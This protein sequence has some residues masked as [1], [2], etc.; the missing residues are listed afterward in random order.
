[1]KKIAILAALVLVGLC[2]LFFYYPRSHSLDKSNDQSGPQDFNFILP[3]NV[4]D[5]KINLSVF[6][7]KTLKPIQDIASFTNGQSLIEFIPQTEQST[8]WSEII[9]IKPHLGASAKASQILNAI[10]DS[11][12]SAA[13][14][15]KILERQDKAH[16]GYQDG[17]RLLTYEHNKSKE[18]LYVYT[19]SGPFDAITVQYTIK[20]KNGDTLN[21]LSKRLKEFFEKNLKIVR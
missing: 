20:I 4:A 1:M 15:M 18:I 2:L 11:I 19:A 16:E 8:N 12:K 9:T 17:F 7:E 6:I 5:G 13:T 14:T 21:N 3:I 10:T